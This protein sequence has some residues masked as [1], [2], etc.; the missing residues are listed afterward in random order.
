MAKISAKHFSQ[1]AMPLSPVYFTTIAIVPCVFLVLWAILSGPAPLINNP[2]PANADRSGPISSTRKTVG[3]THSNSICTGGTLQT[4]VETTMAPSKPSLG[5]IAASLLARRNLELVSCN[6]TQSLWAGYGHICQVKAI[7]RDGTTSP[8]SLILKYISPPASAN[9]TD[10]GHI[11][12][13]LSYQVE[14]YFYTAL[15]P[16]LPE[17]VAVADCLASINDGETTA[18]LLKDLQYLD[19]S[20]KPSA[21]FPITLGRRG[22]LDTTQVSAAL[23]WLAGF[24]GHFWTRVEG[25]ERSKLLRPP[26][27]EAERQRA[28]DVGDA[29][30]PASSGHFRVDGIWL[31]GGYTY[32]ATRRKE[33]GE[34]VSDRTS[35]WS[36]VLC[37]PQVRSGRSIAEQVAAV[38]SPSPD[39]EARG[40]ISE[41]E[42][43]IHGDVKSENMFSTAA[44]Q[45][46]AFF[47]FQYV[48]LGLGV[49]D[50]AK[51]FT[52]SVPLDALAKLGPEGSMPDK[53]AMQPGEKD[54]L[55]HYIQKLEL[56]SGNSYPWNIFVRHWEAALVDWLRFQASW[57][58]WGNTEW[59][60]ARVA[61]IIQDVEFLQW[62]NKI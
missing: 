58:F 26:L 6:S 42:T 59:L 38:L 22:E 2:Y 37:E 50:L 14:Q 62:L 3:T 20:L 54:L 28:V 30:N 56:S 5:D 48:G 17:T 8:V 52:C 19:A 36:E 12:K 21:A 10:E 1:Q 46:V 9:T 51:L 41:Y 7:S 43:I 29:P 33:Y 39:S 45:D 34:L 23:N 32:L 53:L 31:N 35:E 25:L 60:E 40:P 44:G 15:A 55:L 16:G 57:G 47:D 49:C 24:H 4:Q 11:R 18:I 13:V 61:Y 27:E